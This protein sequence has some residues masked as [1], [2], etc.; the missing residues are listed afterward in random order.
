MADPTLRQLAA[1]CGV[2]FTTMSLALRDDPR[3]PQSTRERLKAFAEAAGYRPNPLVARSMAAMRQGKA[4]QSPETL[5]LLT[6]TPRMGEGSKP[7]QA[8][9]KNITRRAEELGYRMEELWLDEPGMS[10]RRMNR[11]I[12]A[13]GVEGIIIPPGLGRPGGHISLDLTQVASVLH[14]HAIWR[15]R[16][17][18]VEAHNFQNMLIVLRELYR[19][20]YR[21][22]G[23]ALMGG[24]AKATGH[25]WEGAYHY[26]H[27]AHPNLSRIPVLAFG[28]WDD[29]PI[30]AWVKAEAPE[31]LVGACPDHPA[32]FRKNHIRVPE[33]LGLVSMGVYPWHESMAGLDS[34]AEEVDRAAVDVLVAQLNRNERGIP[35]VARDVLIQGIWQEGPTIRSKR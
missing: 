24:L 23:L 11:I 12:R 21:R 22:I 14:C 3:L 20:G 10:T 5:A 7:F 31:V 1:E 34:R 18:R 16:L 33:D 28:E 2:H 32:F 19:R 9:C 27:A 35:A 29:R 13:R 30:L 15:P 26:F 4:G 8:F 17:H 25:E 6:T